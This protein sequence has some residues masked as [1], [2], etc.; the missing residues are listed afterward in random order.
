MSQERNGRTTSLYPDFIPSEEGHP[1]TVD[2]EIVNTGDDRGRGLKSRA[3]FKRGERVAKLSGIVVDHTTLDTIQ[4]SPTLFFSDPWF[5][6]FLLHSCDPNLAIDVPTLEARALRDIQPGEYMTIDYAATDD[7]VTSQFACD[8][9][10]P[11]C[12]A[13]VTGRSERIN[14]EGRVYLEINKG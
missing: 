5:C 13:W 1:A 7:K 11:N 10:S 2:F 4:I 12:R 3:T 14:E 8:C 9:G 6:R